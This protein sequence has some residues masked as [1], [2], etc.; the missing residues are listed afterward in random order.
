MQ[1]ICAKQQISS[2]NAT[3]IESDRWASPFQIDL[4]DSTPCVQRCGFKGTLLE[5][6]VQFNSMHEV[7]L[8]C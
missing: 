1:S 7:P 8:L 6:I 2:E 5:V 4:G 3:I